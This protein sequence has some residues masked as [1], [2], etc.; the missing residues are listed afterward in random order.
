MFGLRL[1]LGDADTVVDLVEHPVLD[2]GADFGVF[3][4]HAGLTAVAVHA[5]GG[6]TRMGELNVMGRVAPVNLTDR[7]IRM[8]P[9]GLLIAG[10]TGS[11]D[12]DIWPASA[13]SQQFPS[14]A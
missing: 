7:T 8:W 3:E 5:V 14:G 1:G 13:E 6:G 11:P 10:G 9:V 12:E 2:D 4:E